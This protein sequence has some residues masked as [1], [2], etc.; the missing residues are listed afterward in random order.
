MPLEQ[1]QEWSRSS[2]DHF[3]DTHSGE[4]DFEVALVAADLAI[5]RQT[6]QEWD[7]GP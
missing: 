7:S 3:V 2:W 1:R 5:V 6:Q 4:P